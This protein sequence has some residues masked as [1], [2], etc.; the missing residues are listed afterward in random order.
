MKRIQTF[1]FPSFPPALLAIAILAVT[2]AAPSLAQG[3]LIITGVSPALASNVSTTPLVISG[4]GFQEGAQVAVE[5]LGGDLPSEFISESELHAS[6]P[7]GLTLGPHTLRV[8]N[9]DGEFAFLSNA[10]TVVDTNAAT[11]PSQEGTPI[12]SDRPVIVLDSYSPVTDRS[13]VTAG[14]DFDL[15][16]RVHNSGRDFAFNLVVTFASEVFV[17]RETGGVLALKELDPGESHRIVQPFTAG[18]EILGQAF[19][20][21]VMT[22]T[23][24][25]QNG[26]SYSQT[27][28][29]NVPVTSGPAGPTRTP[30]PTATP[31]P[32]RRPQLVITGY[33]TDQPVLQPGF[34][35]NLQMQVNNVGNIPAK[36]VTMILGGGSSSASQPPSGTPDANGTT[37]GVS[38]GSGDFGSFAPLSASNVQFLGDLESGASLTGKAALI[39]NASTNPGAYPMKISFTYTGDTGETFTDDQVIT[40]LVYSLPQVEVSFYRDPGPL[41]AGQPNQLPIQLTNLGKK[42][43][44]LGKM[45]I[46]GEGAQVENSETLVGLLDTGYPFTFDAMAIPQQAGPLDLNVVIHY[47]DDFNQ[48][49]AITRTLHMEVMEAPPIEP[50]PGGPDGQGQPVEPPVQQPETFMQK[51]ARFLRGLFGLNSAQPTQAPGEMPPG[52]MPPGEFPGGQSIPAP[53]KG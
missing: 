39:V 5:G 36:R 14:Q 32:V 28:N 13:T 17:P 15:V 43:T 52:E 34:Q 24:T 1:T 18:Y 7:P 23:Y 42:A 44:V 6:L 51:V 19:G 25:D 31:I 50:P 9:P 33:T 3:S 20:A 35:F 26:L 45:K 53:V 21:V 12:P 4:A 11:S 38:G 2:L 27:F 48:Q 46:S 40:L 37:G 10:I 30:T 22:A 16:I 49:Q 8:A 47:T 29:L 41:M